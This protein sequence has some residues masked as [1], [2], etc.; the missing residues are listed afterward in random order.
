[1]LEI[2]LI[3]LCVSLPLCRSLSLT[4]SLSLFVICHR[5]SR[6]S[7]E[8]KAAT[9]WILLFTHHL[10]AMCCVHTTHSHVEPRKT[11]Y[12]SNARW[13]N[14]NENDSTLAQCHVWIACICVLNTLYG[15]HEHMQNGI[16]FHNLH[17]FEFWLDLNA[18]IV[19]KKIEHLIFLPL[20]SRVAMASEGF[21]FQFPDLRFSFVTTFYPHC[22]SHSR[23]I[24]SIYFVDTES[25]DWHSHAHTQI[26]DPK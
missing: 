4:L 16:Q 19:K 7:I 22:L 8:A 9:I 25:G 21:Y 15:A 10:N 20:F 6:H 23:F 18:K 1:M 11:H 2:R 12:K 5:P 13:H 26:R 17:F 24:F 3:C 14:N